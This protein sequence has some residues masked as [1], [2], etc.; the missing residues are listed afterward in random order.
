MLTI[1]VKGKTGEFNLNLPTSIEEI[2]KSYITGI[3]SNINVDANYTL[4]GLVFKEKLSTLLLAARKNTKKADIAVIPIF[5]KAGKSDSEFINSI[6]VRDKLIISPSDIMLGH[7]IS[8]PNN[9]LTINNIIDI[10][11]EDPNA[12]AKCFNF[13][14]ECYFIEFKLV[15]NCNIHGSYNRTK[16]VDNPYVIKVSNTNNEENNTTK[17]NLIY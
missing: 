4:I 6:N 14:E 10:I 5:A 7:H 9:V 16:Y 15:P 12:Y 11:N 13:K 3:T 1:N 17:S 8:T 2:S